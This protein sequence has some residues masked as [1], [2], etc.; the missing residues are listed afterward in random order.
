MFRVSKNEERSR[1]VITIDGELAGEHTG[2]VEVCC[3]QAASSG[4]PVELRLRNVTAVDEDGRA[5]LV[6]LTAMGVRV[7]GCGVYIAHVAQR[8]AGGAARVCIT[9]NSGKWN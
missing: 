1:T 5:L 3:G 7:S 8:L 2:V 4:L 6:R 9:E